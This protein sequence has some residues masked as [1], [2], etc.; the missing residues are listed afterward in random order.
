MKIYI[1]LIRGKKKKVVDKN[2]QKSPRKVST[3]VKTNVP[4][5]NRKVDSRLLELDIGNLELT[6]RPY[7]RLK[8]ANINTISNLIS[9]SKDD[10]LSLKNFGQ[11]SLSE[12]EKALQLMN[13]SLKS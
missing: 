1:A 6:A 7:S 4:F 5:K 13:L 2:N 12:V 3:K 10:L 8:M 11:R 9:Y